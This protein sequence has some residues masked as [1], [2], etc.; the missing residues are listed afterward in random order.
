[1]CVTLYFHVIFTRGQFWPSGIVIVRVCV[2]AC[3][4]VC[5]NHLLLGTIIIRHLFKLGSLN[6]V[7]RSKTPWLR[8]LLFWGAIDRDLQTQNW[9][10]FEL[11]QTI[12]H[13][14]F[15][16]GFPNLDNKCI[17]AL[18][19]SLLIRDLIDLELHLHFQFQNL[20]VCIVVVCTETV[21]R[22]LV[23]FNAVQGLFHSLYSSAPGERTAKGEWSLY[24]CSA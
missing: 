5:I 21:K 23:C 12:T 10:H 6:L 2:C 15:K 16:L 24:C 14:L 19:R 13:H 17:L 18:L 9:P 4:C 22:F 1:M 20:F 7:Q 11:V 8:F 3:V